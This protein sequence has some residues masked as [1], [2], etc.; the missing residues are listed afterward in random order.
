[1]TCCTDEFSN[2]FQRRLDGCGD[3]RREL[4]VAE[5]ETKTAYRDQVRGRGS[6]VDQPREG[7]K[8]LRTQEMNQG[9]RGAGIGFQETALDLARG[10]LPRSV[11]EDHVFAAGQIAGQFGGQLLTG[12][13]HDALRVHVLTQ[14][15]RQQRPDRIVTAERVAVT[16]H[17][18]RRRGRCGERTKFRDA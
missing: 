3:G 15:F 14:P 12:Q 4:A 13:D 1:M 17:Q 16:D 11:E 10:S 5:I 7:K 2:S 18:D 6:A 9:R 8:L